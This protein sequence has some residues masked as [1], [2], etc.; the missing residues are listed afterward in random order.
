MA[1]STLSERRMNALKL[2]SWGCV[3]LSILLI[4]SAMLMAF[5]H[6]ESRSP[7]GL[8]F[9]MAA[10]PICFLGSA[11]DVVRRELA[12]IRRELTSRSEASSS[13]N[14]PSAPKD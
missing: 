2:L 10:M 5:S 9:L 14:A 11:L 1:K 12:D 13:E 6:P 7:F 3:A 8:M 4:L